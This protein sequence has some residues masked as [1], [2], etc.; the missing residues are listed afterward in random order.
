MVAAR[1]LPGE[2]A[3]YRRIESADVPCVVLDYDRVVA[4]PRPRSYGRGQV[5]MVD[6][7][8][9]DPPHLLV[10][11]SRI[12]VP[13]GVVQERYVFLVLLDAL[14]PF[15]KPLVLR[16]LYEFDQGIS[17]EPLARNS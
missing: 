15:G 17:V 3:N 16:L 2:Q 1:K 12:V 14:V 5:Y 10:G 8:L 6:F 4:S 11:K 7:A 9:S 13:H